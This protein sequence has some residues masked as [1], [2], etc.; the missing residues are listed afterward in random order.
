MRVRCRSGAERRESRAARWKR[1]VRLRPPMS[2]RFALLLPGLATTGKRTARELLVF[3]LFLAAAVVFTWP[4]AIRL[5]TSV[6]DTGDPLLNA[7]IL[8]WT[9]Y[10]LTHRPLELF[11]APIFHTGRYP[12]A[13]SEHLA[14]IALIV[15]P[16][17]LAGL[18][19]LALYNVAMLLGFAFSAYGAF[20]LARLITGNAIAAAAGGL[21]FGF[22][23]FAVMH[24]SHLQII[25]SGW[26]PLVLASLLHYW[27]QP[28]RG[29]AA[30]VAGAFLMNGL[31]NIYW[32]L[33]GGFAFVMTLLLLHLSG[34][35]RER[36]VWTRLGV[37]VLIASLLLLPFLL[38][39]QIVASEYG[40]RRTTAE[41]RLS[42]ASLV[43]WLMPSP[44]N[45][46]YGDLP[47][48]S[49]QRAERQLFPGVAIL[50]L[51]GAALLMR[52]RN[53][54]PPPHD[55]LPAAPLPKRTAQ[56]LDAAIAVFALIALASAIAGTVE[57]GRLR[58][59]GYDVPAVIALAL[60]A[61]R[62]HRTYPTALSR[63]RFNQEELAAALWI[64]IGFLGSLGWN[65]FLHPFLFRVVTPFRATRTPARWAV[66]AGVGLAVWAAIGVATLL[67][68]RT[69]AMRRAVAALLLAAVT[70]E[71]IPDVRWEQFR[72]RPAPVYRWLAK[73]RP[74]VIL[75]LPLVYFGSQFRSVFFNATHRLP[76]INGTSG[77]ESP[78]HERLKLAEEA[79]RFDDEFLA[80]V[81]RAGGQII[82]VHADDL[83]EHEPAVKAWLVRQ[84]ASG[85]LKFL[86][87][88]D[89][90]VNGDYV[91]AVARNMPDWQRHRAPEVPDGAAYLPEQ[92][93]NRWL[94]GEATYSNAISVVLEAP[95]GDVEGSLTVRGFALSPHELRRVTLCLEHDTRR[96][97]ARLVPRPDV[98]ARFPWYRH[99]APNAGFE[100]TFPERPK[101]IPE[102]TDVQVEVEDASGRIARS[103]D[104]VFNWR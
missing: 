32:L 24:T 6:S 23:S 19:P 44:N 84:L 10:A 82:I 26:L 89:H 35:R 50:L 83:G 33:Y 75:E 93:L 30:L 103:W 99:S 52:R 41:G 38:P 102:R 65:A 88:F 92:N 69:P 25:W 40:S 90:D 68:R 53:A 94:R 97:P 13:Y 29:R 60:L 78:L 46:L 2:R 8:D 61:V 12:L 28:S 87:R 22:G 73:E 64:A 15:L 5:E 37:A 42:S 80:E 67:A 76:T 11:N 100:A 4:L 17:H 57:M 39:Y 63:T 77:W 49:R 58:W 59:S 85:R 1:W 48:E 45:W 62:L 7:W 36:A 86:R 16:F 72:S 21:F 81:E 20:V 27:R 55:L 47:P 70:V 9:S 95:T 31:T 3:A 51:A 104:V 96:Y 34:P 71:V 18:S 54:A 74:G 101:G 56:R 14:G 98:D 66:I 79:S 91:F 43:D